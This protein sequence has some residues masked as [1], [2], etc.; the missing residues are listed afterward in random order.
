M[1]AGWH[2][3]VQSLTAGTEE[4]AIL[5]NGAEEVDFRLKGVRGSAGIIGQNQTD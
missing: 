1:F 3:P 4:S 2:H 5:K